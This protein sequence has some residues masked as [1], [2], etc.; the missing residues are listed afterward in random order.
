MNKGT[1]LMTL[2]YFRPMRNTIY[3]FFDILYS[4]RTLTSL[5]ILDDGTD[6]DKY[7]NVPIFIE[8]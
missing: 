3:D 4:I 8:I 6:V 7:D 1:I 2:I 5:G